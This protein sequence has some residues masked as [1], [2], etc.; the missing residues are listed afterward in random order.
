MK[1]KIIISVSVILLILILVFLFNYLDLERR[2]TKE[3][4]EYKSTFDT[5]VSEVKKTNDSDK[6][7]SFDGYILHVEYEND[8]PQRI[9]RFDDTSNQY[10]EVSFDKIS[11]LDNASKYFGHKVDMIWI[12]ANGRISIGGDFRKM[13][14]YSESG[15]R[16][17]FYFDPDDETAFRT[18]KLDS[19]WYLLILK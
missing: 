11:L 19:N 4:D 10:V 16:P 1:K 3:F 18:Y 2:Y 15:K 5:I 14:V 12:Y 13:I 6:E 9:T 8:E 7:N 17:D